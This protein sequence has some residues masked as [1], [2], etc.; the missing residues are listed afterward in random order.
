MAPEPTPA[1]A[2]D[3][4]ATPDVF[5]RSWSSQAV[6]LEDDEV[7]VNLTFHG[8]DDKGLPASQVIFLNATDADKFRKGI[9]V[10]VDT[11]HQEQKR[12]RR[13][14]RRFRP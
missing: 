1:A 11:A 10:S 9:Q 2:S 4:P 3:R 12:R 14:E 7:G 6:V 8:Q 5:A 13:D